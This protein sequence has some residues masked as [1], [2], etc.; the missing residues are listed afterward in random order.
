[1]RLNPVA[2]NTRSLVSA[3]IG[4]ALLGL[5]GC[6]STGEEA[7]KPNPLPDFNQEVKLT[8][9]WS[10]GVGSG[11]EDSWLHLMPVVDGDR[12]YA[13][14][15]SGKVS[16]LD[17]A[18]GREAWSVNLETRITGGVGAGEGLVLVGTRDGHVIALNE[19]DGTEAWR[20]PVTSEVLSAPQIQNGVVVAQA[21]DAKLIALDAKDGKRLWLQEVIQPVL[22]LR[23]TSTPTL[24]GGVVYAGF[25]NGEA[26]AYRLDTGIPLWDAKVAVPR[27]SSELERMVDVDSAP[28]MSGD[29]LYLV[30]FQGNV[31]S[32][33]RDGGR[34]LWTR[35][36]SSYESMTEGFGNIY[37]SDAGSTVSAVDQRTGAIVWSQKDF[38]NRSLSGPSAVG[39][40]VVAG[41][42]EGYLHVISQVDGRIVG[43][44]KVDSSGIRSRPLVV[45]GVIYVYTNGGDLAALKID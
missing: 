3:V 27:G 44:T 14:G 4:M 41:D 15:V 11:Q 36:A 40:Y 21:I 29:R 12:I 1:M 32:L 5:A 42:F 38:A 25:A 28:L 33:D 24:S 7:V 31:V 9:V 43:R 19:T 13:A 26:R 22:T 18:T 6:S 23:G 45:D 2:R 17:K 37:L 35:E 39:S 8:T 30:S 10:K 16:A 20:A 34:I